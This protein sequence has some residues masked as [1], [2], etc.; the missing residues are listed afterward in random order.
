MDETQKDSKQRNPQQARS[1]KTYQSV[2]ETGIRL[3]CK[4]G[5]QQVQA[6]Q[7]AKEAGVAIGSFYQ[8]FPDKKAVY[9][10]VIRQFFKDFEQ[11]NLAMHLQEILNEHTI[12]SQNPKIPETNSTLKLFDSLEKWIRGYGLFYTDLNL[13]AY[14]DKEI[15]VL[16]ADF[17]EDFLSILSRELY[18]KIPHLSQKRVIQVAKFFYLSVDTFL[19]YFIVSQDRKEVKEMRIEAAIALQSYLKVVAQGA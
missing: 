9:A 7:I 12:S 3:F 18:S 2:L 11:V 6:K 14:L 19:S 13:T 16:L 8:Y 4:L 1:K 10:E 17:E 5:Y 15:E